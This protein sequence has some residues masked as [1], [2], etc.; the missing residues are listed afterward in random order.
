MQIPLDRFFQRLRPSSWSRCVAG[1][2]LTA[3]VLL[4]SASLQAAKR[5]NIVFIFSDDHAVQAIGAYGSKVNRT[6]HIDRLAHEGAL[7]QFL[8]CQF[9]LWPL[10][11]L[12]F[13]R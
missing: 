7:R 5:P 10:A 9:T 8:L 13:E 2:C 11:C 6:P 4:C 3:F 12:H 1:A